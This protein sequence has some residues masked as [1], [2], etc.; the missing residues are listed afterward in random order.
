MWPLSTP[1]YPKHL[2][3]VNGQST[4]LVQDTYERIKPCSS[5][6]YVVTEVGHAHH[7]Q[8]QLPDIPKDHFIIEPARRGTAGCIVA[9]LARI[10]KLADHDEPIAFVHAD[11][12]VRDVE[13]FRHSFKVANEASQNNG[14]I[15]L[16]G[17][18]PDYPATGFG[19]IEKGQVFDEKSFVFNVAAF[20]EKP[21]HD[22]AQSYIHSGNYLW[23]CGYFVGSINTFVS[24]MSQFAPNLKEQYDALT[25]A[26]SPE[27]QDQIYLGF[28]SNAI[29]YALIERVRDLLVVPAS[30][31]WMDLGSYADLHKAADCDEAGNH[32]QGKSIE[33]DQVQN[34]FIHNYEDKPVVVV[35]LDN[36]VVINTKHG[37][38]VARK[39]MSQAVGD[40]AK[41]IHARDSA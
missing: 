13:G 21:D 38:V 8:E 7:V 40:A 3:K 11:H 24:K 31:D 9:G 19:Y 14:R 33:L 25:Q 12:Y 2:L 41:K 20:K 28:D 32:Q 4:T 35:G 18:E 30:F 34:S 29:D 5:D 15:V 1:A 17:V 39:D 10:A 6:I 27:D 26:T 23:N 37:I 16:V 22:L 36:V